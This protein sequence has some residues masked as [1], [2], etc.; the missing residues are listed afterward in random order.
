MKTAFI[1]SGIV[2][3]LY[4]GGIIA[5]ELTNYSFGTAHPFLYMFGFKPNPNAQ[6]YTYTLPLTLHEIVMLTGVVSGIVLIV[7]GVK[8]PSKKAISE[9]EN[10]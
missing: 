3:A 8:T 10:K 7:V 5:D 6:A 9:K 1:I 4:F 2:L